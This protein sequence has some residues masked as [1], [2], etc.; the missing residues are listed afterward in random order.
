MK[1]TLTSC[2]VAAATNAGAQTAPSKVGLMPSA[3]GTYANLDEFKMA[4]A[5]TPAQDQVL[6]M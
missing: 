5:H 2:A 1:I 6:R 4:A 3:T